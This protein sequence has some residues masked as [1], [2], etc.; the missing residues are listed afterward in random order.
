MG[1]NTIK[2]WALQAKLRKT[3]HHYEQALG[4]PIILIGMHRSGTSL[5]T[6][7]LRQAGGYF[8]HCLDHN[9][10][11]FAYIRINDLLLK[12]FDAQWFVI[13][14]T[15][16]PK[17]LDQTKK[18]QTIIG[19]NLKLLNDEFFS[20]FGS[21]G[22][23]HKGTAGKPAAT[24]PS[25]KSILTGTIKINRLQ[26]KPWGWKDPRNTIT[27]GVWLSLFPNAKVIHVIRNGVDVAFSLWR[28]AHKYGDGT[29]ECLDLMYCFHLWEKYTDAGLSWKHFLGEQYFE[30]KYED[31]LTTPE[32]TLLKMEQFLSWP[33]LTKKIKLESLDKDRIGHDSWNNHPELLEAASRSDLFNALYPNFLTSS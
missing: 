32:D 19:Q 12:H 7:L 28:R 1:I 4:S 22:T 17:K 15:L 23:E 31:L 16:D 11:A 21:P 5:T 2:T 18:P 3:L 29:P 9:S 8:G 20:K 14:D 27:L 33:D 25:L 6:R 30:F 26:P 24:K 13:P 10:E